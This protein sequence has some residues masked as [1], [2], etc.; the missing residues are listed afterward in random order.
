MKRIVFLLL[1][2]LFFIHP[3]LPGQQIAWSKV[4]P[5]DPPEIGSSEAHFLEQTDDGGFLMAGT[6]QYMIAPPNSFARVIKTDNQGS[7]LW[8]YPQLEHS[9]SSQIQEMGH[10]AVEGI[11]KTILVV[12]SDRSDPS[13]RDTLELIQLSPK[14]D[15]LQTIKYLLP[16]NTRIGAFGRSPLRRP[17]PVS[18]PTQGD[19]P[20]RRRQRHRPRENAGASLRRF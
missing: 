16:N 4:F 5:T 8:T 17:H 19:P 20:L 18:L 7:L 3:L 12:T 14:G 10:A 2:F 13:G 6:D 9:T 11:D 15:S 1:P